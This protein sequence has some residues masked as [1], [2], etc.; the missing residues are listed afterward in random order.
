MYISSLLLVALVQI[1]QIAG[2]ILTR[3]SD[4]RSGSAR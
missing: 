1:I 2:S 3:A 4:H